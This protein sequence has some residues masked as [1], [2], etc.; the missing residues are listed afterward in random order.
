M[1]PTSELYS[2][3]WDVEKQGGSFEVHRSSGDVFSELVA[4][5]M[6]S[7]PALCVLLYAGWRSSYKRPIVVD[8]AQSM[9]SK[10]LIMRQSVPRTGINQKLCRQRFVVLD[11]M[12]LRMVV[13]VATPPI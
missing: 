10:V 1:L 12:T 6:A 5:G 8:F 11:R 2:A 13:A 7:V 9:A 3:A 4:A